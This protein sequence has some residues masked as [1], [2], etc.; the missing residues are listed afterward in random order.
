MNFYFKL[1]FLTFRKKVLKNRYIVFESLLV[2]V[3]YC[4]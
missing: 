2:V 3:L 1:K 4:T